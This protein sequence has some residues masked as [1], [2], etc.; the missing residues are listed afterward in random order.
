MLEPTGA[1]VHASPMISCGD[2]LGDFGEASAVA[3]EWDDGVALYVDEAGADDVTGCIHDFVYAVA[4][5]GPRRFNGGYFT[6]F[7]SDVAVEIGVA[8]A[9]DDPA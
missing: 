6:I 3:H 7:K 2:A 9:V 4:G 5:D 8:S 1:G